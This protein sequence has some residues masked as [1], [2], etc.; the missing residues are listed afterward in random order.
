MAFNTTGKMSGGPPMLNNQ[1]S[2]SQSGE[3]VSN[4]KQIIA[5]ALSQAQKQNQSP[6]ASAINNTMKKKK[7]Y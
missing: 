6:L 4:P 7:K 2:F 3:R 1:N 5:I